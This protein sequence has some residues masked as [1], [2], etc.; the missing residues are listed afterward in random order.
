M[1]LVVFF[2]IMGL[3]NACAKWPNGHDSTSASSKNN[4]E[5]VRGIYID[6]ATYVCPE[7]YDP[8]CG[9]PPMPKCPEGMMCPQVMP[10][11]KTYDN[12]CYAALDGAEILQYDE[13]EADY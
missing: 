11:P 9:Q 3:F 1:K 10:Q 8:V 2:L 5:E 12:E 13:C 7:I 4:N 6:E